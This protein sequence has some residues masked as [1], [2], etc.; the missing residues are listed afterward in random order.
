MSATKTLQVSISRFLAVV[1][2]V[3]F[4]LALQIQFLP[5]QV[6]AA[7]E[8]SSRGLTL[9][10][11][12]PS[13][14]TS[15]DLKFTPVSNAQELIVDFCSNSPLV[16]DTCS[17]AS[18]SVPTI[19]SPTSSAGTAT[20]VG[21][22]SPGHTGKVTWLT[23]TAGSPF[24][25]N[26]TAGFTNPS[27][28]ATFYA[29]VLTYTTG[30][31]A[32]YVPASTT[33]G[34]PTTGAGNV[35]TGGIALSTAVNIQIQAKVFETMVF[36]IFQ[37]P[38][39]GSAPVLTL[40]DPTTGALS[41]STAYINTTAQY[42]LAT[43]AGSGA[44]VSMTGTTLCRASTINFTNCPTGASSQTI[45]AIG[46]TATAV[47][48]VHFGT[49]QFGMCAGINGSVALAS[50]AP[51]NDSGCPTTAT[52]SGTYSGAVTFGFND[53]GSTGGS[54]STGGTTVLQS[55]VGVPSVTSN[56]SFAANISATTEAGVY[57]SYLD[58]VAT[59]TF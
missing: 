53:S 44:V 38:S 59:A 12:A 25:L 34:T 37:A 19:A 54:N 39:C 28:A 29:R 18:T 52:T 10:S 55:S 50:V 35:D 26:F 22:G 56:F 42:T 13:A 27:T 43:N 23:M 33:G 9:G 2:A 36:C 14:V 16:G 21:T 31:A 1:M 11:S 7:G 40:G 8:I 47:N 32:N 6:G 57:Q 51:Y 4:G 45:S 30:N 41:T 15:Y 48:G 58:L 17:F 5:A 49:E 20:A 46:N 24:T 3:G